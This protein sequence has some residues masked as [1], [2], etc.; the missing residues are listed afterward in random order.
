MATALVFPGL[1]S[2]INRL[3]LWEVPQGDSKQSSA[4]DCSDNDLRQSPFP[5]GA[6]SGAVAAEV[7]RLTPEALA[8][9]LMKLSLADHVWLASMLLGQQPGQGEEKSE[10]AEHAR[11]RG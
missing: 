8:A 2:Q 9:A 10:H 7:A 4:T 1:S 3:Q 11:I 6:E 5:S